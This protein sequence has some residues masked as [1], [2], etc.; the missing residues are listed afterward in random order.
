MHNC[1]L[2]RCVLPPRGLKVLISGRV[3]VVSE[4][5][6]HAGPSDGSFESVATFFM[7]TKKQVIG[8]NQ[9]KL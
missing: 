2:V 6:L 7:H 4:G 5:G 3:S 8:K 9:V 1:V